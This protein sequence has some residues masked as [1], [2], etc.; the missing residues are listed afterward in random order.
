MRRLCFSSTVDVNHLFQNMVNPPKYILTRLHET[1]VLAEVSEEPIFSLRTSGIFK[2][3]SWTPHLYINRLFCC[4]SSILVDISF[5]LSKYQ[6]ILVYQKYELEEQYLIE[7][8]LNIKLIS[9][10]NNCLNKINITILTRTLYSYLRTS[11]Q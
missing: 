1:T 5:G 11:Q 10:L 3:K 6:G 8:H 7:I 2:S 9:V 4:L